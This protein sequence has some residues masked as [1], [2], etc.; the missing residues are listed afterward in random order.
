MFESKALLI[1]IHELANS[2]AI[3]RYLCVKYSVPDHWFPADPKKR[4]IL[5]QYLAWVN[6]HLYVPINEYLQ[7]HVFGP[8]G[9][10]PRDDNEVRTLAQRKDAEYLYNLSFFDY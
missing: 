10:T 5:N 6:L 7:Q 8:L 9:G 4:A 2:A 1:E 3:A